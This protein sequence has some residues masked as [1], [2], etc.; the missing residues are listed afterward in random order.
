LKEQLSGTH[1]VRNNSV[2][3]TITAL[4]LSTLTVCAWTGPGTD[5]ESTT[6]AVDEHYNQLRTLQA[7]FTEIYSGAGM[8]RTESGTLWLK[9]PGKMRWEYRSP[10]D[11]LFL[12]DGRDAWFYLPGDKQVRKTPVKKLE[13]LRSPLGLLLGKTRLEKELH[14]L[15]FSPDTAPLV[16]G[17]VV[18]RGIPRGAEDRVSDVL[19]EITPE[20]QIRRIKISAVDGSTT[21]YRFADEKEDI[22]VDDARFHFVPPAG[23]ETVDGDIGQ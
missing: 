8:E 14:S 12:S 7:E 9:K 23:V 16:A 13:D 2:W 15:G 17:D 21:E 4:V 19:L 18:L 20:H 1:P 22:P 3:I 11:K 5:L 6:K 10:R